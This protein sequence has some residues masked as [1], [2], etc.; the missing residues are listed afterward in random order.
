[1]R[2]YRLFGQHDLRLQDEPDPALKPGEVR[3]RMAYVGVCGTDLHYYYADDGAF[4]RP[5]HIGH[6][7]SATV[8][9]VA[10]DVAS[11]AVGDRVAVFPLISCGECG[12]CRAG[13]SI[14]CER[15]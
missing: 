9:E 5:Q 1:M 10:P 4:D 8:I 7:L 14:S 6:E 15:V 3:L 13:Y 12:E 11:V 2:A